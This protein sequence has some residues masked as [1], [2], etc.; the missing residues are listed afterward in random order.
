VV[1][2]SAITSLLGEALDEAVNEHSSRP[3][4]TPPL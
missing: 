1:G 4:E 2:L 3:V